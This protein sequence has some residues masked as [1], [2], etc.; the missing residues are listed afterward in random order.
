M[1]PISDAKEEIADA[2]DEMDKLILI[3][4]EAHKKQ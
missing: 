1:N 2:L 4:R 3:L